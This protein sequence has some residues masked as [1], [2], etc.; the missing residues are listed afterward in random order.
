MVPVENR[1][2]GDGTRVDRVGGLSRVRLEQHGAALQLDCLPGVAMLQFDLDIGGTSAIQVDV[3]Y[4]RPF[5][6]GVFYFDRIGPRRQARD[7]KLPVLPARAFC[8]EPP[9]AGVTVTVAFGTGAPAA[10]LLTVPESVPAV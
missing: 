3:L 2:F 5:V 7:R 8:A 4:R 1:H 6:S 9:L 10:L